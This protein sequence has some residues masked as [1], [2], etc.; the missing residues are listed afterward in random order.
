MLR[1]TEYMTDNKLHEPL[2]SAYRAH[3]S[4]ETA[5]IK[6][7]NDIRMM[8]DDKK[9]VILVLLDYPRHSTLSTTSIIVMYDD[10]IGYW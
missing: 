4:T 5:L 8:I 10:P 9:A 3:S 6:L 1:V 7:Q 2:Q